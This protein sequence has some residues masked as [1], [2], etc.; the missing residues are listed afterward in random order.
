MKSLRNMSLVLAATILSL[1]SCNTENQKEKYTGGQQ[2]AL[3]G[4]HQL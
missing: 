1:A 3:T 2:T 4:L